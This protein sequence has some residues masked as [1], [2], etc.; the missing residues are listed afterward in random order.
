MFVETL[1]F[2]LVWLFEIGEIPYRERHSIG[3]IANGIDKNG[4][5]HKLRLYSIA[6]SALGDFGDSKTVCSSTTYILGFLGSMFYSGKIILN[7]L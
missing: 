1:V 3:V 4:K 2:E 6:S 5:P 7:L